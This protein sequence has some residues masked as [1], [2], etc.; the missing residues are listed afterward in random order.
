M[1]DLTKAP[2][3]ELFDF[4]E[5][6]TIYSDCDVESAFKAATIFALVVYDRCR[7]TL[8]LAGLDFSYEGLK[9]VTLMGRM[10]RLALNAPAL[11]GWNLSPL[12]KAAFGLT[13]ESS[14]R[15]RVSVRYSKGIEDITQSRGPLFQVK[16]LGYPIN[17]S[18]LKPNEVDL[19]FGA[20][21]RVL[22]SIRNQAGELVSCGF[23]YSVN[24]FGVETWEPMSVQEISTMRTEIFDSV[25]E[26]LNR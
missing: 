7:I 9:P 11:S 20:G 21:Q 23:S 5:P 10:H 22:C 25:Q 19:F 16:T 26:L 13:L 14:D 3:S 18:M 17:A 2:L 4:S 15:Q 12:T 1:I 6:V 8:D 24:K